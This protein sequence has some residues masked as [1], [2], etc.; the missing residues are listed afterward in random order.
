MSVF[1]S[2]G[3]L[4]LELSPWANTYGFYNREWTGWDGHGYRQG[5]PVVGS[6]GTCAS[7][8]AGTVLLTYTYRV[9]L[10]LPLPLH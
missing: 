9:P 4:A 7:C 6:D 8:E 3:V 5:S 1:A 10:L 2:E